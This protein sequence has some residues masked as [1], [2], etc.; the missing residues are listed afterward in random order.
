MLDIVIMRAPTEETVGWRVRCDICRR[1][2]ELGVVYV[3][4]NTTP[5]EVCER[6]LEHLCEWAEEEDFATP[7]RG[8]YRFYQLAR[9]HY[10]EPIL[11]LRRWRTPAAR[12]NGLSTSRG[13][14][15]PGARSTKN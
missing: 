9:E 5:D 15:P 7:W 13:I 11:Q 12:R 14:S 8:A 3:W 1:E 6:C 4:L 10:T 2:F